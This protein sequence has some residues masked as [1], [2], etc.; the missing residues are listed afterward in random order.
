LWWQG[1][2]P[3]PYLAE[4]DESARHGR[5][6]RWSRCCKSRATATRISGRRTA[7]RNWT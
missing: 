2:F 1:G 3:V 4:T 6:S 7:G 5:A